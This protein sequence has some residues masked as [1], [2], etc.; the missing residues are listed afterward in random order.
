MTTG[1]T[2]SHEARCLRCGRKIRSAGSVAAGYGPGCRARIRREAREHALDGLNDT[3]R[4]KALDLVADKAVIRSARPGV[5][6]VP[7]GDRTYKIH[8]SGICTCPWGVRRSSATVKP[9]AHI[10]AVRLMAIPARRVRRSMTKA[11]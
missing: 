6:L 10:G 9:C 1:T 4:E 3:Q 5:W 7:S 11:A 8:E 2:A